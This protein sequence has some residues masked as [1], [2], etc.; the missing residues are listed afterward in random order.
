MGDS[1]DGDSMK[2][3]MVDAISSFRMRYVVGV[4]DE[5]SDGQAR[6]WAMD[7]VTCEEVQEFSQEHIGE[8]ISSSRVIDRDEYMAVFNQDN[9][10]LESWDDEMKL[11]CV[12]EL[13]KDGNIVSGQA[14]WKG[15]EKD[16]GIEESTSTNGC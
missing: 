13:D 2:Y 5:L 1:Y 14:N 11:R 12:L 9:G 15:E 6:D 7:S 16:Y 3:V 8:Q 10:Y 4:P